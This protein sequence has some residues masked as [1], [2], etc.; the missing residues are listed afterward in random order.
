MSLNMFFYNICKIPKNDLKKYEGKTKEEIYSKYGT[1]DNRI[2]FIDEKDYQKYS[3]LYIELTTYLSSIMIKYTRLNKSKLKKD[4]KIPADAHIV[5]EIEDNDN[6]TLFLQTPR[7]ENFTIVMPKKDLKEKYIEEKFKKTYIAYAF[8]KKYMR[9]NYTIKEL[10]SVAI[11][12]NLKGRIKEMKPGKY[13]K[14]SKELLHTLC[15]ADYS[16]HEIKFVDN[17]R[18]ALFYMNY[19]S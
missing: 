4:Y 6:T 15:V 11:N 9:D 19:Y 13:Y 1:E 5:N 18:E 3:K 7:Y 12:G 8:E 17:T 10:V 16:F 2:L 14:I